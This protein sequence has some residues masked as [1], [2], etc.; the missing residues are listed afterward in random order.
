VRQHG[1]DARVVARRARPAACVGELGGL[2]A[3]AFGLELED[4]VAQLDVVA[5][6]FLDVGAQ[7]LLF[8]RSSM[9]SSFF[10]VS[11]MTALVAW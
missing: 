2:V 6:L 11:V 1:A 3:L 8:G 9:A 10:C 5:A 4:L 7:R